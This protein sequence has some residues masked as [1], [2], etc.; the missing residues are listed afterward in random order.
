MD[1]S[2]FSHFFSV[3]FSVELNIA[4][5]RQQ[6]SIN[7][8]SQMSSLLHFHS[9]FGMKFQEFHSFRGKILRENRFYENTLYFTIYVFISMLHH[10]TIDH[11]I[12]Y[13]NFNVK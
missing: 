2:L 7:S 9:R 11:Q 6:L 10:V 4:A 3:Y 5:Q 8:I 13:T 12:L 1:F